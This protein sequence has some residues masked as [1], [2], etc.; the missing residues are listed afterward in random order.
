MEARL[1]KGTHDCTNI[2][3]VFCEVLRPDYDVIHVYVT[4]GSDMYSKCIGHPALLSWGGISESH[5]HDE[6]FEGTQRSGN[7]RFVDIVRVYASLEKTVRHINCT[8]D[9][10]FSAVG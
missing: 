9:F 7:R 10:A 3:F 1:S 8:P 5:W 6:P 4:N 2:L